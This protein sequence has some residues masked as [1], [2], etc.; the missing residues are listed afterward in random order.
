MIRKVEETDQEIFLQLTREFYAS[1]AVLHPVPD[2]YH[3]DLFDELM[4]S[5][6]YTEGFM[7]E[8]EGRPVGYALIAKTYSHESGGKVIW[9]EEIYISPS[10]RGKGLG[11]EFF[12]YLQ[13]AYGG[14]VS[15]FRLELEPDNEKAQRLYE[16]IGFA[17]LP[18]KQMVLD[19]P[20]DRA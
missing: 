12:T 15:R 13:A 6:R 16:R 7:I 20:I 3:T 11:K 19:K 14:A 18:Y 9:I 10:H 2:A 1:D 5:D 17:P 4:R 8:W